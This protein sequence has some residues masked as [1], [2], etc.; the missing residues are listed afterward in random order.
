MQMLFSAFAEVVSHEQDIAADETPHSRAYNRA[1]SGFNCIS[2]HAPAPLVAPIRQD[3]SFTIIAFSRFAEILPR[4]CR[5]IMEEY[6][7]HPG[8]EQEV[9]RGAQ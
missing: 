4:A 7:P 2:P 3:D 5:A 9:V 6:A 1:V 8:A